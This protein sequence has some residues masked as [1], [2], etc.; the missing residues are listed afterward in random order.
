MAAAPALVRRRPGD[1]R[2]ALR[3]AVLARRRRPGRGRVRR[4]GS[5]TRTACARRTTCPWRSARRAVCGPATP[6]RSST[7]T[8]ARCIFD[9]LADARTAAPLWRVLAA[10]DRR[11]AAR[12]AAV[13]RRRRP[14]RLDRRHRPAGARAVEHVAGGGQRAPAQGDAQAGVRA[15][16]RAGDDPRARRRPGFDHLAPPRGVAALRARRPAHPARCWRSPSPSC[17]TAPRDGRWR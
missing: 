1:P 11:A 16:G 17:T 13:G 4:A 2:G 6:R 10:G 9:A 3:R 7:R 8:T 5:S 15:V 12:R 14:R